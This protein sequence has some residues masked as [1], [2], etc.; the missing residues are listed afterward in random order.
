MS[1]FTL[2]ICRYIFLTKIWCSLTLAA[3]IHSYPTRPVLK[4]SSPATEE[5]CPKEK[6]FIL[7]PSSKT[8]CAVWALGLRE[9]GRGRVQEHDEQTFT[10]EQHNIF[11][12]AGRD[13]GWNFETECWILKVVANSEL[14]GVNCAVVSSVQASLSH[15]WWGCWGGSIAWCNSLR[16]EH[17]HIRGLQ[18]LCATCYH[19]EHSESI[20]I[21]CFLNLFLFSKCAHILFVHVPNYCCKS[22]NWRCFCKYVNPMVSRKNLN[23]FPHSNRYTVK[24]GSIKVH[25]LNHFVDAI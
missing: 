11:T 21:S 13:Q 18:H 4:T 14:E 15:G 3:I 2:F 12:R 16:G 9:G 10:Q 8:R 7:V 20:N 24:F 6:P 22:F 19:W 17:M 25:D 23:S 1:T 5:L